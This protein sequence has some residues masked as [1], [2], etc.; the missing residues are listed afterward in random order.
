MMTIEEKARIRNLNADTALKLAQIRTE[1]LKVATAVVVAVAAA[2][3]AL[4]TLIKAL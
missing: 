1:R 4:I 3:S 2:M